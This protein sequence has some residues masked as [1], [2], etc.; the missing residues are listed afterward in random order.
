MEGDKAVVYHCLDNA[1]AYRGAA[2]SPLEFELDDAPALEQMLTTVEPR[3]I[4]VKDLIHGDVEDKMELAQALFDEGILAT[5]SEKQM[6][7]CVR[8][9]HMHY[10]VTS[11]RNFHRF[12]LFH[13][14]MLVD[15]PDRSVQVG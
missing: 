3:W 13:S 12:F 6:G 10:T 1:R 11:T 4:M 5:V 7:C 14:K 8:L 15:T 2:L 9:Q